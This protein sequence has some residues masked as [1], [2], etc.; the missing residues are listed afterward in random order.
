MANI[1]LTG[2]P[3]VEARLL[4]LGAV[5]IPTALRKVAVAGAKPM[6]SAIRAAAP[7]GPTGN[8]RRGVR[9]KASRVRTSGYVGYIVG[10]FGR[11][12]AHRHLVLGGH[13]IIGHAPNKTDTG[14]RTRPNPFVETGHHAAEAQAL[15]AT[16]E[17]AAAA[18]EMA[19]KL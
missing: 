12:T 5:K 9:Y 2:L 4:E 15:A 13:E 14:K 1:E 3:E 17:A 16:E 10:P 8:L 11:G 7:V 18:I 19:T 6:R